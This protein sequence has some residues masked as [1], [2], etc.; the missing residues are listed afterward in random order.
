MSSLGREKAVKVLCDRQKVSII[1]PEHVPDCVRRMGSHNSL[2]TCAALALDTMLTVC[3]SATLRLVQQVL[4]Q[5]SRSVGKLMKPE[6]SIVL[7]IPT[8]CAGL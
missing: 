4:A 1:P 2:N 7:F 5:T 3:P 6:L 8:S